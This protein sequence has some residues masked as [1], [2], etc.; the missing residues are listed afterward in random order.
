MQRPLCPK[1]PGMVHWK[2]NMPVHWERNHNAAPLPD[3]FAGLQKTTPNEMEL[4]KK[5]LKK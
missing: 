5:F 4:I 1:S 3:D 2:L